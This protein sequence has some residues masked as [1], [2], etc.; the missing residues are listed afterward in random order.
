MS[1]QVTIV[2]EDCEIGF[3]EGESLSWAKEEAFES[4]DTMG[5][6][7]VENFGFE[8]I[9]REFNNPPMWGISGSTWGKFI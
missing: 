1:Y 7:M 5:R 2:S 8:L 3:G 6:E 9:I 4:L